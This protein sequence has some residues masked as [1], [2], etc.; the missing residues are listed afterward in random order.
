M[1]GQHAASVRKTPSL[2]QVKEVLHS[3]QAG[4]TTSR[5]LSAGYASGVLIQPS[6]KSC[7]AMILL[8]R[9]VFELQLS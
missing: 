1:H 8:V 6:A 3:A 5:E 2:D 9:C 7:V 4:I